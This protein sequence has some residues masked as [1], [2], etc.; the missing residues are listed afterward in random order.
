MDYLD[1]AL[2]HLTD[3]ELELRLEELTFSI[4]I[5]TTH[6]HAFGE[7]TRH[8]LRNQ[9]DRKKRALRNLRQERERRII[10]GTYNPC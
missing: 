9:L 1:D 8:N 3:R 2:I 10:A 6:Y 5:D 7:N 4:A